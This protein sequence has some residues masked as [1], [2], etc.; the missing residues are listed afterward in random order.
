MKPEDFVKKYKAD[1]LRVENE[2]GFNAVAILTQAAF[3]SG[4]G[5]KAV[6]NNFFGEKSF[7]KDHTNDQLIT[8]TE[9]LKT[10]K[11]NFPQIIAKVF[12]PVSKLWKYTIKDWFKKF[13]TPYES[14]LEHIEFFETNKRY[15]DAVKVKRDYDLFF[16]EIS[17]AGYA[18]DPNYCKILKDV[19]KSIIKFI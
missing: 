5:E 17:K 11:A 15:A 8:T 12:N 18:T 10:D 9:Y 3:E 19:S 7:S 2:T 13:N 16:E 1:A 6:G 14:F 4:W